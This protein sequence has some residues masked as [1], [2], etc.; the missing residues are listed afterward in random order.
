MADVLYLEE[1]PIGCR[2]KTV[3]G[4]HITSQPFSALANQLPEPQF[5]HVHSSFVVAMRQ[6]MPVAGNALTIGGQCIPVGPAL[7]DELLARA[8]HL[9]SWGG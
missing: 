9:T 7:E 2:I 5:L 1:L 4:E 3:R 6:A 8:F